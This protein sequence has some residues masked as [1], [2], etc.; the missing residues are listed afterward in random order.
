MNDGQFERA[1]GWWIPTYGSTD[2]FH[3]CNND[4]SGAWNSVWIPNNFWGHQEAFAGDGY[5]GFIPVMDYGGG[6]GSEYFRTELIS[7]LKPC[8]EYRFS[9]YVSLADFSTHGLSKIG[10]Y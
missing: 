2:F 8:V 3:R 1:I 10:A 7:P 5:V 4:S 9:M 6:L